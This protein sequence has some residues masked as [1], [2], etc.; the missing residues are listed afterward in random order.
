MQRGARGVHGGTP[1]EISL[2]TL[3]S[4]C[5]KFGA[6]DHR[7]TSKTKTDQTISGQTPLISQIL[8]EVFYGCTIIIA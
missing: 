2:Y 3:R 1:S 4:N 8:T 5:S 6:L 7:V